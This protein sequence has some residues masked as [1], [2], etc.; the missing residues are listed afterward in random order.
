MI[1][2]LVIDNYKL[3]EH[4]EL[5]DLA[6]V[7][8]FTGDNNSGKSTILEAILFAF[9][10]LGSLARGLRKFSGIVY[11]PEL[12][13]ISR[14]FYN[15]AKNKFLVKAM[16]DNNKVLELLFEKNYEPTLGQLLVLNDQRS[17]QNA[18]NFN[19]A[20]WQPYCRYVSTWDSKV[21]TWEHVI[22]MGTTQIRSNTR[23]SVLPNIIFIKCN[24]LLQSYYP[25]FN[26]L[27]KQNKKPELLELV[28]KFDA[29]IT[30]L[31]TNG[32]EFLIGYDDG[33]PMKPLRYLGDGINN[34]VCIAS[35]IMLAENS[36]C[37][38]DEIEVGVYY[39]KFPELIKCIDELCNKYNVQLFI[40]THSSDVIT[41]VN[42]FTDGAVFKLNPKFK[43][44]YIRRGIKEISELIADGDVDVR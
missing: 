32:F 4:I 26:E 21:Y 8:I 29:R 38:I 19:N 11:R 9:V 41:Y 24:Q 7:N 23:P 35:V 30:S 40:T 3:F 5:N 10:D 27:I 1:K 34:I 43:E 18:V 33:K 14:L 6:R 36:I 12:N 15:D 22:D 28:Q 39:K 42:N 37:L 25:E 44:G 2:K 16:Y 31:E 20:N 13:E 17:P